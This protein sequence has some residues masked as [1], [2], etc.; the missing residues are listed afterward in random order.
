MKTHTQLIILGLSALSLSACATSSPALNVH[1][2]SFGQAV[3]QNKAAQA[4]APTSEQKANTH[5]PADRA[6]Q[7]LARKRYQEDA[8]K[9]P[10]PLQTT[11]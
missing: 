2:T 8:V 3:A 10:K 11:R 6:R 9:E 5:I 7:T 1:S 4:I